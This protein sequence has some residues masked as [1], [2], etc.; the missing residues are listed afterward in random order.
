MD[1]QLDSATLL[2]LPAT[3]IALGLLTA[4]TVQRLREGGRPRLAS[5]RPLALVCCLS[6][7]AALLFRVYAEATYATAFLDPED[8]CRYSVGANVRPE[9]QTR[10]PLSTVCQGVEVV[11]SWVNPTLYALLTLAAVTLTAAVLV[12]MTPRHPS[13]GKS[14]RNMPRG[15]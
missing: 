13:T 4:H 10:F 15:S 11:P 6:V 3:V 9:T 12:V 7:C 14:L 5:P 8:V 1:A 2:A